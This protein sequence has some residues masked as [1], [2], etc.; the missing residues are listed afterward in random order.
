MTTGVSFGDRPT[1]DAGRL[2]LAS[3][4]AQQ[5]ANSSAKD[6]KNRDAQKPEHARRY[7][8]LPL[9]RPVRVTDRFVATGHLPQVSLG[10][11]SNGNFM[12]RAVDYCA[13][14][15]MY[16]HRSEDLSVAGGHNGGMTDAATR[17]KLMTI[18]PNRR[19]AVGFLAA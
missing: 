1:A 7:S 3:G 16:V 18:W 11:P 8:P 15:R 12:G 9:E 5:G 6:A 2:W 10:V 13:A 19:V 14:C 4:Y 17:F